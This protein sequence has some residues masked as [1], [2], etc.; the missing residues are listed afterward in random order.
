MN[1][2]QTLSKIKVVIIDDD[3]PSIRILEKAL[4]ERED[5]TLCGSAENLSEG[6]KLVQ[7]HTP[8]LLFLDMEFPGSNG[9]EWYENTNLPAATRVVF[10][11]CY[12]R[13]IHDAL[14]LRV[15]DFLLKPFDPSDLDVIL[16]R[17]RSL[18]SESTWRSNRQLDGRNAFNI[19]GRMTDNVI[20]N[21][22][23]ARP[24]AITSVINSKIIVNPAEIV[25]FRYLSDR[26]I[27]E[28]VFS[29]LKRIILKKQ[30]TAETILAYGSDFVRTHKQ[31]IVNM[32]YV[33]IISGNDCIL[34]PPLDS[35]TEIKISKS[36]RRD[37]LDRFYD[38]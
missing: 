20:G 36:Y 29:N 26:K 34:L 6:E 19:P 3:I 16:K 13:Y 37:L 18:S 9:L 32:R 24:L 10:H 8:D 23:N 22:Y 7:L 11:T 1:T 12:K 5:V 35:I 21:N 27:W 17:F 31:F 28:C 30:T 2:P 15:F 14:S 33:G 38:I 25:Y 4:S